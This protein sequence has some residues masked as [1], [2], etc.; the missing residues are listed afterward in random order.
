[1]ESWDAPAQSGSGTTM[2][3]SPRYR[4]S[5]LGNRRRENC[6]ARRVVAGTLAEPV[7]VRVNEKLAV[8][9]QFA[10]S[11]SEHLP[12]ARREVTFSPLERDTRPDK[13]DEAAVLLDVTVDGTHRQL[14][15]SR[16]ENEF[17]LRTVLTSCG[18]AAVTCGYQQV[19]LGSSLEMQPW[20]TRCESGKCGRHGPRRHGEDHR[21][22]QQHFHQ[23]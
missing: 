21:P 14:W 16:G 22:R 23:P 9:E 3:I 19:P 15:L 7:E 4:E 2:R 6:T 8:G 17:S 13:S 11:V 20:R 1:M 18:L 12:Y 10:V 5:C